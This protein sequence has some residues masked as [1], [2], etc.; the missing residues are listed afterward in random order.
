[1]LTIGFDP[2]RATIINSGMPMLNDDIVQAQAERFK[3]Q[4][5]EDSS[6]RRWTLQLPYGSQ[7]R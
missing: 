1:M 2:R 3:H 7:Y 6:L 4:S 5:P